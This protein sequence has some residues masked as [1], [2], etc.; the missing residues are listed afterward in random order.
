MKWKGRQ[1]SSN[2]EDRRG[3]SRGT[4]SVGGIGVTGI[5][6]A[7]VYT[8]ITGQDPSV[9][10]QQ[11]SGVRQQSQ[12]GYNSAAAGENEEI[13]QFSKVVLK[14]TEDVWAKLFKEQLGKTYIPPKMVVF[15]GYT[16][17]A[18]GIAGKSTGPYYCPADRKV[19]MDL[20]FLR[21]LGRN[22]GA[23]GDFA[24]AYVIAHEVGHHIQNLLGIMEKVQRQR[25]Y[26][27]KKEY[28][29]L[30]VKLELQADFFAG[31]W[32]HHAQ[33][34]KHIL[35]KGDIEEALGAASAV[36]DDRLQKRAQ[37]YV[38]PDAFT[39]GTSKQRTEW[40]MRGFKYGDFNYSNTFEEL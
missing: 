7:I 16:T 24:M 11:T 8:L 4:K 12:Q 10:L 15:N 39:H 32:A 6:I 2:V 18:C 14:D 21:D 13:A 38:V 37:G 31:M 17:G 28:N 23:S 34:M 5:I 27:S 1:T 30:S 33:K 22:Y 9:I 25:Q 26:L 20:N 36:G 35:E 29:K 3:M 19:Y 40:F